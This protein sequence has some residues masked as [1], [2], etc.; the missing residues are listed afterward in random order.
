MENQI[1]EGTLKRIKNLLD[2]ADSTDS[3][4]EK[5]ACMLKIQELLQNHNLELSF[6]QGIRDDKFQEVVVKYEDRWQADLICVICINNFCKGIITNKSEPKNLGTFNVIGKSINI[7]VCLYMYDFY[8]NNLLKLSVFAYKDY[9]EKKKLELENMGIDLDTIPQ[10]KFKNT[11]LKD[12]LSGGVTGICSK[13]QKQ[14][15]EAEML[16]PDLKSLV[17]I[18]DADLEKEYEDKYPERRKSRS[19]KVKNYSAYMNGYNDGKSIIY[20]SGVNSGENKGGLIS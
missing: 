15:K 19:Q 1:K 4:H 3:I 12:Y 14:K 18:S 13:M 17:L 9:L 16:N 11:F 7:N 10:A 2:K 8:K 5:D 20:G 6:V